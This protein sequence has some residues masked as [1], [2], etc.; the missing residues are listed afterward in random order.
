MFDDLLNFF[1][2]NVIV[3]EIFCWRFIVV[4][5]G[6]LYVIMV[7]DWYK[8]MYILKGSI[9]IVFLWSSMYFFFVEVF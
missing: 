4:L 6:I 9:I 2:F 7:D 5:G 3:F 8:G 1:Y